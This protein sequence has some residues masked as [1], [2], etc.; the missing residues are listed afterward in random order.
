MFS[1][2]LTILSRLPSGNYELRA[3]EPGA[4]RFA[5]LTSCQGVSAGQDAL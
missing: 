2:E 3:I 1:I 5:H 4:C